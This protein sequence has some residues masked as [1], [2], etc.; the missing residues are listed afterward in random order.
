MMNSFISYNHQQQQQ[1]YGITNDNMNAVKPSKYVI[2]CHDISVNNQGFVGEKLQKHSDL[3]VEMNN[4]NE[5]I[6]NKTDNLDKYVS[7]IKYNFDS[8]IAHIN[9]NIVTLKNILNSFP[10]I[11]D[12]L[13]SDTETK[14][15][16]V[17]SLKIHVTNNENEIVKL[18]N[19]TNMITSNLGSRISSAE[20]KLQ[21]VD[22]LK[23]RTTNNEN[24]ITKLNNSTNST[25]VITTNLAS[26]ISTAETKILDIEPLKTRTTNNENE[27]TKLISVS[28]GIPLNVLTK[29]KKAT[30]QFFFI[31]NNT[32]YKG[33]G[34]FYYDTI[35]DLKNGYFIT[36]AH[37]AILIENNVY[38]KTSEGYIQNPIN[39]KWTRIDPNKIYVDGVADIALIRT[40]IDFTNYPEYCLVV[41]NDNTREGTI[42]FI[43]GN[44][45]GL[46][47]DSISMGY[48]RDAHYT[49]PSGYQITDCIYTSAPGVGGNSGGPICNIKGDVI[50]I[51]TFGSSTPGIECFGG[52]SNQDVLR[53]SLNILKTGKDNKS[54]LYLGLQWNIPSPFVLKQYYPTG[55]NFNSEGV[56][57]LSVSNGSPFT[58]LSQGDILLSCTINNTVITFGNKENQRTPGVLLYYPV[59]TI[60]KINYI[61]TNTQIVLTT[62]VT[63]NKTYADVSNLLDG[64][65]QTGKIINETNPPYIKLQLQK[66]I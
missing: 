15:Q 21:D 8:D 37:C 31:L 52:G 11:P 64:P 53:N 62:N 32:Y 18:T 25:N 20:T 40:D 9:M 23:I 33:S 47:E 65:I 55:T 12:N 34:F 26:R 44:P 27:I 16:D 1:L 10:N 28:N 46:D 30:S 48:L 57:I 22:S 35:N 39:D 13:L 45:A 61:K 63:L 58:V 42:C 6:Q 2:S 38:Y 49:E 43:I 51:Y 24:E 36:A 5:Q 29:L 60:I 14:L 7:N 3:F 59:G 56:N 54:K 66:S 41:S 4:V 50:G 17:D 19:S